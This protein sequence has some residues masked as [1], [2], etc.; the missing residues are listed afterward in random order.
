VGEALPQSDAPAIRDRDSAD[1]NDGGINV[2]NPRRDLALADPA[3]DIVMSADDLS[4][5]GDGSLP[6]KL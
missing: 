2:I 6:K 3:H 1:L 5:D 4:L